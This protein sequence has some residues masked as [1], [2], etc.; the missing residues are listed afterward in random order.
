MNLGDRV[1]HVADTSLAGTIVRVDPNEWVVVQ[2]DEFY[3]H[4]DDLLLIDGP[5]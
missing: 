2:W 5:S 1:T 3:G 4:R